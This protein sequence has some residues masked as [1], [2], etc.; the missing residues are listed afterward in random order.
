MK[1]KLLWC[2]VL[3]IS[4]S[5]V[6]RAQQV[7]PM[8]PKNENSI[9]NHMKGALSNEVFYKAKQNSSK[10]NS[11]ITSSWNGVEMQVGA[12]NEYTYDNDQLVSNERFLLIESEWIEDWKTEYVYTNGVISSVTNL[13]YDFGSGVYVPVDQNQYSYGIIENESRLISELY[14]EW[15]EG[16]GWV[17]V[18]KFDYEYEN[19]LIS[20]ASEYIWDI[21]EWIEIERFTTTSVNDT[22]YITYFEPDSLDPTLWV[23]YSREIY[24][25][26]TLS[27]LYTFY[28][29]FVT[30][31]DFG[32]TYL[33][34]EFPDYIY[35]EKLDGVWENVDGLITKDYFDMFEGKLKMREQQYVY[36]GGEWELLY[37]HEIWYNQKVDPDSATAYVF[38]VNGKEA[39]GQEVYTYN[40]TSQLS[41]VDYLFNSGNGL[42]LHSTIV[43]NWDVATSKEP[44]FDISSFR[45]NPAYP[46]PFNPSTN[47]SYSMGS[48]GE[49]KISVYDVLG[50][51][52]ATLFNGVQSAGDHRLQ[53]DASSLSSGLYIVSM[54]AADY[55]KIQMITLMK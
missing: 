25:T 23:E 1:T 6:V 26:L 32:L 8:D 39:A 55:Q 9:W 50:R 12:K 48:A 24:P 36:W 19:G 22:T 54:Q 40:N 11:T 41:E 46:N 30:E 44:K 10:L 18:D 37:N 38:N 14:R 21:T 2:L 5:T 20:G 27:E 52:V 7:H 42:T 13:D 17:A 4:L 34:L 29:E 53:F 3:L 49:I 33:S 28:T 15:V 31:L 45:L 43:L 47:I 51:H 35:Q 16:S